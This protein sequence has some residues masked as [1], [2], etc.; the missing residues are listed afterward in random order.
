MVIDDKSNCSVAKPNVFD[1]LKLEGPT[2]SYT[3]TT[4]SETSQVIG[5]RAHNLII[6]SLDNAYSYALPV[7]T[8]CDAILDS[9]EDIPSPSAAKAYPHLDS[10]ADKTQRLKFLCLLEEMHRP[11]AKSASPET[12]P[13]MHFGLIALT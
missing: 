4:C 11:F 7:L 3:L 12:D 5:R 6:E 9:R 10:F 1:L 8:E 2:T 13:G